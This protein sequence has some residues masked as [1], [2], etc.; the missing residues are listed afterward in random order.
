MAHSLAHDVVFRKRGSTDGHT[1]SIAE[2]ALDTAG[3]VPAADLES[4][5]AAT[6]EEIAET[7]RPGMKGLLDDHLSEGHYCVLLSASPQPLVEQIAFLLDVP[8]GIGTV[9]EVDDG[10]LTG[11]IEQP[12][13]YG[14]GKLDRLGHVTGWSVT[15]SKEMTYAYADSISDLPLLESVETPVVVAPDRRLRRLAEERGWPVIEF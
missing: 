4:I 8:C 6:A 10:V 1:N 14:P 3:G 5:V 13:C 7:V 15:D 9:I 2:L 12:M 11:R